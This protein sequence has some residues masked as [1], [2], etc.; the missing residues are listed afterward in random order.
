MLVELSS[1]TSS[2][3]TTNSS[4][5]QGPQQTVI[6][7]KRLYEVEFEKPFITETQNYYRL[8]SN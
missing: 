3:S 8:E 7:S 2:T 1:G 6:Q 5:N 4:S